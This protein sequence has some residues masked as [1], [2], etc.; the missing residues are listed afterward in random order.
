MKVKELIEFLQT[1]NPELDV[2]VIGYEDG[3]ADVEIERITTEA[4]ERN[5]FKDHSYYGPHKILIKGE[6][7]SL[8]L[9]RNDYDSEW[10]KWV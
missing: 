7:D 6:P 1:Q 2:M 9:H 8:I 4:T 3:I 5:H 10:K